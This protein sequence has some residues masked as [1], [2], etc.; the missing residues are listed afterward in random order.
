MLEKPN[1]FE[2]SKRCGRWEFK[3]FSSIIWSFKG[4]F[5]SFQMIF[6]LD[7]I[8]ISAHNGFDWEHN[9]THLGLHQ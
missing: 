7:E 2:N 3:Y 6:R 9:Y 1:V 8:F 4:L 5:E